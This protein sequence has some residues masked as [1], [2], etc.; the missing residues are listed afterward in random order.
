MNKALRLYLWNIEIA[1]AFWGGFS[2]LEVALRNV[3]HSELSTFAGRDDWWNANIGLHQ[4]EQHRVADAVAA[5]Q[6]G[7]GEAVL[8]GHVVAELSFGF[9]TGLLANR[10]HQ[11]LWV[12]ALHGAFPYLVGPRRELHRKQESL[13]KLRNRIAHHEPIFARNLTADHERLLS[14]LGAISP[15]AVDW[16]NQN[17]RVPQI[18]SRRT[19]VVTGIESTTF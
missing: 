13:R 15:I 18:I 12:P 8:P 10:Y 7:K 2:V 14:I 17:S 5:A 1:S 3:I 19:N 16:V 4:L 11:R 9:W 6:R